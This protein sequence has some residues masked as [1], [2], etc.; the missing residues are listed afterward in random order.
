MKPNNK[1]R[2]AASFTAS[3]PPNKRGFPGVPT[4]TSRTVQRMTLYPIGA[5]MTI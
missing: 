1:Y 3:P 2:A 4:P 5:R